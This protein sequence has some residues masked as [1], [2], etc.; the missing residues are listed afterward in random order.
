MTAT[1]PVA[2]AF[3]L[4]SCSST[5]RPSAP[6][7]ATPPPPIN[8]ASPPEP[9]PNA[10][11]T[12]V[13]TIEA[14]WADV[15]VQS[16]NY[17]TR[18]VLLQRTDGALFDCKVGPLAVNFDKVKVGDQLR[19]TMAE[20]CVTLISKSDTKPAAEVDA[21]VVRVLVDGVPSGMAAVTTDVHAKVLDVDIEARRIVAEIEKGE[22]RRLKVATGVDLANLRPG[23]MIWVRLTEAMAVT[24]ERPQ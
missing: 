11:S 4:T 14:S 18:R 6:S 12:E 5:P 1:L 15:T 23:D 9:A 19:I 24:I 13:I 7:A 2:V 8:L 17:D 3:A 10:A 21:A 20:E 22:A 16:I